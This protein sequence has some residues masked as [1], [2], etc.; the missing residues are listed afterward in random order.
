[1]PGTHLIPLCSPLFWSGK[2][3]LIFKLIPFDWA[4]QL[5]RGIC[6]CFRDTVALCVN[7][8]L[9]SE[10]LVWHMGSQFSKFSQ[11]SPPSGTTAYF[12]FKNCGPFFCIFSTKW[13]NLIKNSLELQCSGHYGELSSSSLLITVHVLNHWSVDKIIMFMNQYWWGNINKAS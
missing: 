7:T 11:D 13:T 4:L 6:F 5:F 3:P 9:F 12:G 2:S 8:H 10:P 1:M